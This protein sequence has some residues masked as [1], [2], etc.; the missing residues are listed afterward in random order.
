MKAKIYSNQLRTDGTALE[1]IRLVRN[2]TLIPKKAVDESHRKEAQ[3]ILES[4]KEQDNS[5]YELDINI[6]GKNLIDQMDS[7]FESMGLIPY[8]FSKAAAEAGEDISLGTYVIIP[9]DDRKF[10]TVAISRRK[11]AVR[12]RDAAGSEYLVPWQLVRPWR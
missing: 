9:N 10:R 7:D 2:T 12:I 11:G 1:Y 5:G 6:E 4:A 8:H 3:N